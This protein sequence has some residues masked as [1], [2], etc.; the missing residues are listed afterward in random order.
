[1]LPVHDLKSATAALAEIVEQ[2]EG[3]ARTDVGDGDRDVFHPDR[4][5]VAHYFRFQELK[6]GRR[7][8][9]GD[10]PQ[11]GPTG[12]EIVVDLDGV[13]PMR[14]NPRTA[15]YPEGS[16]VRV[17]QEEF[18]RRTVCCSSSWRRLS[19]ATRAG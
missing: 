5:E 1:M 10:T 4:E 9:T 12:E 16:P 18:N 19:R 6:V 13:L 14:H 15:D 7:Y 3:A 8:R 11:S 17:A 2:G